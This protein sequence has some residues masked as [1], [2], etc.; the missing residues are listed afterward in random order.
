MWNECEMGNMIGMEF[1][2][3]NCEE[4][5]KRPVETNEIERDQTKPNQTKPEQAIARGREKGVKEGEKGVKKGEKEK[6]IGMESM[7]GPTEQYENDTVGDSIWVDGEEYFMPVGV[8]STGGKWTK[9]R[10]KHRATR[11]QRLRRALI[12]KELSKLSDA[13]YGQ[14][15]KV[16]E[17]RARGVAR[18]KELYE[19]KVEAERRADGL[20]PFRKYKREQREDRQHYLRG[21]QKS[22]EYKVKVES[23]LHGEK[24]NKE[25]RALKRK[26]DAEKKQV[27]WK[28]KKLR[29]EYDE[30]CVRARRG[31][32]SGVE[33]EKE[34]KYLRGEYQKEL[35]RVLQEEPEE[36]LKARRRS[37]HRH[38]PVD[39]VYL[40]VPR[41]PH[42]NWMP[43]VA[44]REVGGGG[45][46]GGGG[47]GKKVLHGQSKVER[48]ADEGDFKKKYFPGE[49]VKKVR[50][51]RE[52]QG[53]S[54]KE[55]GMLIQRHVS[56]YS[57]FE[58]GEMLYDTSL[59]SM[60]QWKV[61]NPVLR[62]ERE[63]KK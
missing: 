54:Q 44:K 45:G 21:L 53:L 56:E 50:E 33:Q 63:E 6:M 58:R 36:L 8:K 43:V 15:W 49:F 16:D 39:G 31:I 19:G 5:I 27:R 13:E 14:E 48:K 25:E 1:N 37:Q 7:S 46:G 59:K 29:A 34:L 60:L 17:A 9:V 28:L 12:K 55:V 23:A 35:K 3:D 47:V 57:A 22:G 18:E 62:K 52:K 61:V 26:Y 51:A 20:D 4:K 10:V 40:D 11:R 32:P 2:C 24:L 30:D 41:I 38:V 42:Q